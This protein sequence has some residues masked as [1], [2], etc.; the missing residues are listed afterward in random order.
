MLSRL[1]ISP[2]RCWGLTQE[3]SP[4]TLLPTLSIH[5]TLFTLW[6]ETPE[7]AVHT[8]PGWGPGCV[9]YLSKGCCL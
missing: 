3:I 2:H 7:H 8:P 6:A 5:K 9:Y 1:S 4:T